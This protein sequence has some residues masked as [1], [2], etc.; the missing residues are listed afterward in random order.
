MNHND[1]LKLGVKHYPGGL[2]VIAVRIDKPEETLRKELSG[3]DPKFKLGLT[4]ALLVS[5]LLIEAQS[6]HCYAFIN[7]IAGS[8][9]RL[10]ELP[11]REMTAKQDIR[12]DMAGMLKEC[13]DA[14]QV[15][16]AALAD[17]V[18]SDN[19]R[20]DAEKELSE[21]AEKVQAVRRDVRENNEASK[22]AALRA[23]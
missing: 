5:D 10:I 9:G 17:N 21:L 3:S 16:T 8:A 7:A 22:P 15:L 4:T 6:P 12:S 11:V 23:A 2:E 18:L 14:F 13:S 20:R 1:A 19:E